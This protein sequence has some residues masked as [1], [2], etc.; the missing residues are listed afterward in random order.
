M[1]VCVCVCVCVCPQETYENASGLIDLPDW[2]R[3]SDQ[4]TTKTHTAY[5]TAVSDAYAAELSAAAHT[6]TNVHHHVHIH[7]PR[8]GAGAETPMSGGVGLRATRPAAGRHWYITVT[9]VQHV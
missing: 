5:S 6:T 2:S 7:S 8:E 9:R 1:C 3:V 4:G